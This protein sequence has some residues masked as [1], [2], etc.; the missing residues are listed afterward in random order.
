MDNKRVYKWDENGRL[1]DINWF[2]C[3]I[4]GILSLEGFS[5][6]KTANLDANGLGS[7]DVS[8]NTALTELYC[9]ENELR[10]LDLSNNTKMEDLSCDDGLVVTGYTGDR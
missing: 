1:T 8:R 2:D 10:S 7:L 3:S 9:Y 5:S 4:K 6:L